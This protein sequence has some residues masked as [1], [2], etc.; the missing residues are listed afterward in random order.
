MFP[1][2]GGSIWRVRLR[3]GVIRDLSLHP[4]LIVIKSRRPR[5]CPGNPGISRVPGVPP[6]SRDRASIS[7]RSRSVVAEGRA[8]AIA[9]VPSPHLVIHGAVDPQRSGCSDGSRYLLIRIRVA[10]SGEDVSV[11][12]S[13]C[14]SLIVDPTRTVVAD[15]S[16]DV[17]RC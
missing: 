5:S 12:C 15:S 13:R 1:K 8:P 3:H 17:A 11:H 10:V 7:I 4:A 14:R 9:A 6:G 2:L 16:T